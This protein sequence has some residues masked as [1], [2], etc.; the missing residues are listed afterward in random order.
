MA[1]GRLPERVAFV[2]NRR[3]VLRPGVCLPDKFS[4]SSRNPPFRQAGYRQNRVLRRQRACPEFAQPRD[5]GRPTQAGG[6]R[7]PLAPHQHLG[8]RRRCH[9]PGH[10]IGYTRVNNHV[11]IIISCGRACRL[12]PLLKQGLMIALNG[13]RNRETVVSGDI[14]Q[15]PFV[16]EYQQRLLFCNTEAAGYEKTERQNR[17]LKP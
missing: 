6:V 9:L 8:S 7:G 13:A 14:W 11:K 15:L 3:T 5:R 4:L 10:P 12:A 16:A 1:T 2:R 17:E